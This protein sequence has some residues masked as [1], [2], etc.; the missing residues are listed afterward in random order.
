MVSA[1]Y[2]NPTGKNNL[3][4]SINKWM[5]LNIPPAS[6]ADFVYYFTSQMQPAVFPRVEV[7]EFPFF[8]PGSDALGS[9]IYNAA[10]KTSDQGKTES[11]MIEV[12][13]YES[14]AKNENAKRDMLRI[15]DRLVKG[16]TQAGLSDDINDTVIMPPISVLDYDNGAA[17]TGI[18]ARFCIEESNAKIERYY[19]PTADYPDIHRYQ[20]LLKFQWYEMH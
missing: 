5:Q 1:T 9:V 15:R 16:I 2:T 11:V 18:V 13:I 8:S 20:I 19:A 3:L 12:N 10:T 7:T 4:T 6:E 17:D 14:S